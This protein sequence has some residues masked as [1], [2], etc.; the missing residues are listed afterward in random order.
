MK[1]KPSPLIPLDFVPQGSPKVRRL[2]EQ[3]Q[4]LVEERARELFDETLRRAV[5]ARGDATIQHPGKM[6]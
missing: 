4:I 6:P 5:Q 2:A 1:R 3:L